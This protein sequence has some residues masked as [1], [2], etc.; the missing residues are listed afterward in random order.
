MSQGRSSSQLIH[1]CKTILSNADNIL[2]L[3]KCK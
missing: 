2:D 1:R 3:M